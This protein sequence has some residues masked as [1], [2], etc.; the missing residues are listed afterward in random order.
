VPYLSSRVNIEEYSI[1]IANQAMT[2]EAWEHG[3]LI[4]LLAAYCNAEDEF[5]FIT[6][7]SVSKHYMGGGIAT[8]LLQMCV[9]YAK[10]HQYK[11]I[12]LEVNDNVP[13]INFY[14]KF[15]F[16]LNE[17]K[18]NSLFMNYIICN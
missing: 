4:G 14:K 7:V 15:N 17:L 1:K 3:R 8:R 16:I 6:S 11:N 10:Q 18:N 2:F 9:D 13:A 12:K 5:A